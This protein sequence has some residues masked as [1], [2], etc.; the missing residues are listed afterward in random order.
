MKRLLLLTFAGLSAM[1]SNAQTTWS[2]HTAEIF[3]D[4][5]V[6]CHRPDG[7][8]PFSLLDYSTADI[9]KVLIKAEVEA[10]NMPPYK[11]DT[12]FQH[13]FDEKILT[14]LERNTIINWVN[15]GG[16]EGDPALAPPA[17]VFTGEKILPGTP[18][19]S[20]TMP[21]Y[22]SK[23][24]VVQDD[25]VCISMPTGLTEERRVRAIE[26]VPGNSA[27]VHHC[28]VYYD[29]DGDYPT[30]TIGGDCGGPSSEPL[31][32]GYTPGTRPTV[33]PANDDF[34]CG[35]VMG[36]G[37]NV[38]FAMHYPH[39]SYG[40]WDATTVNFYFYDEPMT[41]TFRQVYAAPLNAEFDF[42]IPAGTIDTLYNTFD[43]TPF[44]FTFLSVF[45][46]MH[47]LG[48][49]M[50]SFAVTPASDTVK[51]VRIP[52]YDFDWQD[53]Y[54]FQY[55]QYVPAG[56]DI[57]SRAIYDNTAGNTHNPYDPP[58]DISEGFNTTDEMYLIYYHFMAYQSGDEL[59][60]QDELIT[61]FLST[62]MAKY[63][64]E[65]EIKVYPNPFNS[66]TTITFDAGENALTSVY[67]YDLNGRVVNKLVENQYLTGQQ[68]ILWDGSNKI[69]EEATNG[70]YFYS[71]TI[72][73]AAYNGRI[74]KQ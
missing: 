3:F 4:N 53:F 59:I 45:P 67:I 46:H 18:D 13:Y 7:I 64:E 55:L 31:M 44:D 72:N 28:L 9:Y 47:L 10:N 20:I 25:Y 56:S 32:A 50:Q 62:E 27:T 12:S 1:Y 57:E 19:L 66:S 70:I 16:L 51:F 34:S 68:E 15:E 48:S 61:E 74:L 43:D 69:G 33:F 6:V 37:S 30:D 58:Q 24:T 49:H 29:E 42:T 60:N 21:N 73:G 39:G 36:A 26:I 40:T 38:V 41:T 23:A 11:A 14:P 54:W 22:M 71:M 35:M 65:S 52:H 17:P 2:E 63:N 5:C 8:G